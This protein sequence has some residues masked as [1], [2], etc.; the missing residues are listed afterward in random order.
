MYLLRNRSIVSILVTGGLLLASTAASAEQQTRRRAAK[1]VDPERTAIT[2]SRTKTVPPMVIPAGSHH[3]HTQ[4]GMSHAPISLP[5]NFFFLGSDPIDEIVHFEGAPIGLKPKRADGF[6]WLFASF[7]EPGDKGREPEVIPTYDTVME[8]LEP[9][10]L[11][12]I[13]SEV[14]V[15][16][17]LAVVE[18]TSVQP[19]VIMGSKTRSYDV[20]VQLTH[21]DPTG[22]GALRTG[23]MTFT[24]D[25]ICTGHFVSE[26][27]AYVRLIF[28]P[29]DGGE[30]VVFDH[31]EQG[32][33]F[34]GAETPFVL[35]SLYRAH[36]EHEVNVGERSG[37]LKQQ[38]P[39][40]KQ[41]CHCP[42]CAVGGG[43]PYYHCTCP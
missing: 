24:R 28:T 33:A 15:P 2:D 19:V 9:A 13:G 26:F 14:T 18:M 41:E 21:D 22:E 1:P 6:Q 36:L 34:S 12:E 8:Q 3:L 23:S 38:V 40:M 35:P 5:A 4:P 7:A 30:P 27:D 17:E 39:P 31:E 16:I 11:P 42:I 43:A 32:S 20:T 37:V 29:V 25:G 10:D